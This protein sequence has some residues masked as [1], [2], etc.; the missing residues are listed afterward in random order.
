ML[1]LDV[2]LEI[3]RSVADVGALVAVEACVRVPDLDVP[4]H[5]CLDPRREVAL[6]K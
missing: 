4:S 2:L 6:H 3:L 1:D 5:S